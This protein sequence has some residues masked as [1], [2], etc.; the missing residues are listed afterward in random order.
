MSRRSARHCFLLKFAAAERTPRAVKQKPRRFDWARLDVLKAKSVDA[1]SELGDGVRTGFA[2][3]TV[4]FLRIVA[5][6]V[7]SDLSVNSPPLFFFFLL[8]SLIKELTNVLP[9]FKAQ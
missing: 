3:T 9:N 1:S 6:I 7:N 5:L 8:T 4:R 2:S